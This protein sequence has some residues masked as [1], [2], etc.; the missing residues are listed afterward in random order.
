[1]SSDRRAVRQAAVLFIAAGAIGL[2]TDFMPGAVGPGNKFLDALNLIVGLLALTRLSNRVTGYRALVFPAFGMVVIGL[3]NAAGALPAPT[4]GIWFVLIFLWIG[5]WYPRGIC[6]LAS[7]FAAAAYLAPYGFG[8]PRTT[9]AVGSAMLVIP[10]AVLA[11]EVIA[12]NV[13]RSRALAR[14]QQRAV[15]ALAKANLTDDLTQLGNRRFGNQI[16]DGIEPGDALALLDLDHFK[17]IN[18]QYGHA[19]GD[20]VLQQLGDYLRAMVRSE[21]GIA[22][23]GGEEFM[24]ILHGVTLGQA[25]DSVDRLIRGWRATGPLSTLSAGVALQAAGRSP[26]DTYRDADNALYVAKTT[27]RDRTVLHDV[28][29]AAALLAE[30]GVDSPAAG[31]RSA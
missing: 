4:L 27:G 16:L 12:A 20:V 6:L 2:I 15:D 23:M 29:V 30:G 3:N 18:D 28:A 22:R 14:E 10:V 8:A 5:S 11:G 17:A 26:I 31:T 13:A 24:V 7:P 1:M 19:R 9:G 21:D 25:F